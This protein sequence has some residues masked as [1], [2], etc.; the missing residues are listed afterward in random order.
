M[1]KKEADHRGQLKHNREVF[2]ITLKQK[3]LLHQ[4]IT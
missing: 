2:K 3:D 1:T 4:Y